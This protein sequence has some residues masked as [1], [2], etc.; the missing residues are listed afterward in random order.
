MPRSLADGHTKV[1][2]L[3]TEPADPQ[4][5]TVAELAAGI[6]AAPSILFSDF[7]FT[8]VDSDTVDEKPLSQVANAKALGPS[9]HEAGFTV[10]RYFDATTKNAHATEDA[11]F[12]AAKDKGTELW[13]YARETAKLSTE[14][15][16]AGD[17]IYL[18]QHV[19][20]DTPQQPT[21]TGGYIKRRV[22]LISQDG[23]PNLLAAAGA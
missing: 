7:R 3:T 14:A 1:A 19:I 18:G 2:V 11:L 8:A 17:E 10:F 6:D 16:A 15:W 4:A 13:I 21:T 9:N 20:T 23:W 22:T 12:D 5:P